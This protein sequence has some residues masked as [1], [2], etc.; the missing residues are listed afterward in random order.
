MILKTWCHIVYCM[1]IVLAFLES[2]HRDS[3]IE[4]QHHPE[5]NPEEEDETAR[6]LQAETNAAVYV[7]SADLEL[8]CQRSTEIGSWTRLHATS[9]S[10]LEL[11]QWP[12][13]CASDSEDQCPRLS[14]IH[15]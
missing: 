6:K 11:R 4:S 13:E 7:S 14:L 12:I 3:S 5:E 8:A 15:I 1:K 2:S 10:D 9:D